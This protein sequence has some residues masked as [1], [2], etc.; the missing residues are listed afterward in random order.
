MLALSSFPVRWF[1][2]ALAGVAVS[3][4]IGLALAGC[5]AEAKA[6]TTASTAQETSTTASTLQSASP[7][8][9]AASATT[10]SQTTVTSTSTGSAGGTF[11]DSS[12][13]HE[14]SVAFTSED[15]DAMI[16]TYKSSGEKDWIKATVTIDGVTYHEVGMRLKGNSSIMGLR[17]GGGQGARGP[18]GNVSADSPQTLPW[19]IRLDKYVDGQ[20]YSGLTD[21]VVRSNTSST[22]LNEAVALQLLDLAGLASLEDVA[23]R[24]SVNGGDEVVRLV[25]QLPDDEWMAETFASTGA[26][27][28]AESSGDY[29]Y[30]GDDP[31]SYTD[32]FDQEAGDD[33]ADLTPLI[34]FLDFINNS[35]DASFAAEL[36]TRLDV[37]AFATYLAMEE[38]LGNFDDIDGPGN[39]SYLYYDPSTTMFTV[40]PWDHNLAFGVMNGRR[41][42]DA[43]P[44]IQTEQSGQAGVSTGTATGDAS[45]PATPAT[46]NAPATQGGNG[47]QPGQGM[48]AH[49]KSNILVTRF[50]ANTEFQAIYEEKL[51]DLKSSLF[52][53]GD[54]QQVLDTWVGVLKAQASDLLDSATID[55][56]AAQIA[57]SFSK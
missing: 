47:R 8:S 21:L 9:T 43:V 24:F 23:C 48:M 34:E 28:K 18:G 57:A 30:R 33:N 44:A 38:L 51:A 29:S 1:L 35:D 39:N 36:P 11:F 22:S 3:L 15:Y 49:G 54:A 52:Q 56:E 14:I 10:T 37:D 19:L 40:V 31:D 17:N 45:A 27:Y 7:S 53:S 42:A 4:V 2:A 13:V 16:Q 32:V 26:L 20:N 25:T 55:Q 6:G 5:G 41:A 12:Q 46:P 50:H